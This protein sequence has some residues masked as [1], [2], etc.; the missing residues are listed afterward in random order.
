MEEQSDEQIAAA[1]QAGDA[2]AFGELIRRYE[3]KLVRYA[4]RFLST[5][6][7]IT[8]LVQ[9]VFV[10]AYT[11][12]QSFDSARRF[13]P[14]LY[15]IAHNTFIN[16]L[17]RRER[18]GYNLFDADLILPQL[19]ATETADEDA[20]TAELTAE[21]A[22]G[23]A[24]LSLKYREVVVLHYYEHLSYQE[25]SDVLQIPPSAVGVRLNRARAKLKEYYE[26][27]QSHHA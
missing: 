19:P 5:E 15:R 1:V 14:W 22:A 11:N 16:E 21:L 4:R 8:D 26:R 9:D 23:V 2:E 3:G 6:P 25:I 24:A 10:K 12:L 20:L 17:K 18:H 7:D 13:S 27:N